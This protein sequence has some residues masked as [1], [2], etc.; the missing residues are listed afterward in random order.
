L[1]HSDLCH[2]GGGYPHMKPSSEQVLVDVLELLRSVAR[3]WEFD[4]PLTADTRLFSDLNFESLD[5]VVLGAAVQEHFGQKFPFPEFFAEIGQ[6][7]D[8]DLTIGEWVG[9]IH[10][11]LAERSTVPGG[12]STQ[13][14]GG[15]A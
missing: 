6:R 3:D 13:P 9:F 7:E 4:T 14:A 5:L 8:R 1:D 2:G 10:D 12:E 11:H 15:R